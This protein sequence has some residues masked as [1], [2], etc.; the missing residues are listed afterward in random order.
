M[1]AC[2]VAKSAMLLP[3]LLCVH[4]YTLSLLCLP[5]LLYVYLLWLPI[6]SWS[7]TTCMPSYLDYHV[8]LV[9]CLPSFL[10]CIYIPRLLHLLSLATY[11]IVCCTYLDFA[12][13]SSLLHVYLVYHTYSLCV[14][15]SLHC[16]ISLPVNYWSLPI[17]CLLYMP[18]QF[19]TLK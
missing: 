7:F 14:A 2:L 11:N 4:V 5:S 17:A 16:L 13:M 8:S 10:Q 18:N 1:A 12:C 6:V 9:S 15:Y 19:T 3:S